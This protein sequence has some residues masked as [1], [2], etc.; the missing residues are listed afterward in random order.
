MYQSPAKRSFDRYTYYHYDYNSN[1]CTCTCSAI[2]GTRLIFEFR[3]ELFATNHQRDCL[4]SCAILLCCHTR[5][6]F[7]MQMLPMFARV[8]AA[9]WLRRKSM[10][11]KVE[12]ETIE[13]SSSRPASSESALPERS[14]ERSTA[15]FARM[16]P[17][18]DADSIPSALQERFSRRSVPFSATPSSSILPPW[19]PSRF[20]L[21]SR[22]FS[23]V[24]CLSA[25]PR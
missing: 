1:T 6:A 23:E 4:L 16:P 13:S 25:H 3:P 5:A 2:K 18:I 11:V 7:L 20:N 17:A 12:F 22:C 19:S 9:I 8:S 24:F 21:K 15:R 10:A 14:S